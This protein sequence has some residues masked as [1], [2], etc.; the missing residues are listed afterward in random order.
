MLN[1]DG[2]FWAGQRAKWSTLFDP[3]QPLGIQGS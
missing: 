2:S 1:L 3:L